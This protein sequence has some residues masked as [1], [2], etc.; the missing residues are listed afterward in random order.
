MEKTRK[1]RYIKRKKSGVCLKNHYNN[2][3]NLLKLS[4]EENSFSN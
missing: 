3:N 4:I 1:T 2:L